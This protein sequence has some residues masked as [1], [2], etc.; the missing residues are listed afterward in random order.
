[1]SE[2]RKTIEIHIIILRV[3]L[4]LRTGME[5][6]SAYGWSARSTIAMLGGMDIGVTITPIVLVTASELV[7]CALLSQVAWRRSPV[8][9][10]LVLVQVALP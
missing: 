4:V 3:G 2:A 10:G 8:L 7:F 5:A 6:E 9:R 1:M